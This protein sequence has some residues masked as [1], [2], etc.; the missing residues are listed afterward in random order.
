MGPMGPMGP[1]SPLSVM[2][3]LSPVDPRRGSND[4]GE[5]R[6]H[7]FLPAW[8]LI[9]A[10][11]VHPSLPPTGRFFFKSLYFPHPPRRRRQRTPFL[12]LPHS[13]TPP[14]TENSQL[15]S[16]AANHTPQ[17][18]ADRLLQR[19]KDIGPCAVAFSGGVDSAVVAKAA[20]LVH[21]PLAVAVTAVSPSLSSSER[22]FAAAE[23][24]A[25]GIR[26][27]E[28]STQEFNRPE[29]RRNTG[30]RCFFCKDTLYSLAASRLQELGVA[31]LVNG[32]NA[33]DAGDY[34]PG[35]QAALQH[36]VRSPLLEEGLSKTAVRQIA[37]HWKLN[38][39]DKP[40]SPCLAS[41]LAYGVEATAE[42]V[43]RV[44]RAEAWIRQQTGIQ[45]LRVR[46]EQS[47]LARI[48]VDPA[49]LALFATDPFRTQLVESL[50]SFGFRA[51]TLDLE[52][53]RSGNLNQL[54]VL[55]G[56]PQPDSAPKTLPGTADHV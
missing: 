42:R 15:S 35:M 9:C 53:F 43:G 21:G 22:E 28:L 7:G 17:Q 8:F 1:I 2:C 5:F 52:G 48:E 51:V 25:I 26:H 14:H 33:D 34:R 24:R 11:A 45:V 36:H 49:N 38:S 46:V 32:A 27:L 20:F 18:I 31:V 10:V 23:A 13:P 30:D 41:R 54:L 40:A 29:Y 19:L 55:P 16:P 39:A 37:V 56:I 50:R 3:C 44:E 47:E 4:D 12:I 6:R